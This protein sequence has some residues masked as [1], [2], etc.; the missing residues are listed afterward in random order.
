MCSRV[1]LRE[2]KRWPLALGAAV[3]AG[4]T[5]AA[6]PSLSEEAPPTFDSTKYCDAMVESAFRSDSDAAKLEETKKCAEREAEYAASLA[7]IW[8]H[9]WQQEQDACLAQTTSAQP[10]YQKLAA[11]VSLALAKHIL[12]PDAGAKT[13][14][15]PPAPSSPPTLHRASD[16]EKPVVAQKAK[17][18]VGSRSSC[19][20][21]TGRSWSCPRQLLARWARR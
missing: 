2:M 3:L 16:S 12:E 14:P 21:L 18:R 8:P 5:I 17:R 19:A 13:D 15:S 1:R 9:V 6:S 7:R 4:A 10:S 11:C 20:H